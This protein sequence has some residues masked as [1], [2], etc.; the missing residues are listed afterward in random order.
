MPFPYER[1]NRRFILN[2]VRAIA[3][4]RVSD[5]RLQILKAVYFHVT[6]TCYR[7]ALAG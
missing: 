4:Y 7:H 2:V 3:A 6:Q 5:V 1:I